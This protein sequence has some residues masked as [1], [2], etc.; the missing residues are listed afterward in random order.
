MLWPLSS[1]PLGGSA[2]APASPVGQRAS[3]GSVPRAAREK[4]TAIREWAHEHGHKIP[5]RGPD[6]RSVLEAYE[7]ASA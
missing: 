3:T 6:P 4:T 1:L 5:D 7:K 2:A